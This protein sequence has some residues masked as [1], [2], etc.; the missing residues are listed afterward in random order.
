[1]EVGFSI[2]SFDDIKAKAQEAMDAAK[3]GCD[4]VIKV[5]S[6]AYNG[7]TKGTVEGTKDIHVTREQLNDLLNSESGT[8]IIDDSDTQDGY[9]LVKLTLI[10]PGQ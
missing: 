10:L 9:N 6:D 3:E 1:M 4:K 8:L 7:A 2:P 5:S